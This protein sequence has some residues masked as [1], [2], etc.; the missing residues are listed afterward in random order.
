MNRRHRCVKISSS[1]SLTWWTGPPLDLLAPLHAVSDEVTVQHSH[2]H[3]DTQRATLGHSPLLP[4]G[5]FFMPP[6]PESITRLPLSASWGGRIDSDKQ[7]KQWQQGTVGCTGDTDRVWEKDKQRN[8]PAGKVASTVWLT[9]KESARFMLNSLDSQSDGAAYTSV[10]FI[11]SGNVFYLVFFFLSVALVEELLKTPVVRVAGA[12]WSS[13]ETWSS[14]SQSCAK[15]YRTRRRTCAGPEGKSAPVACR[16]SPVEYQDCNVQSCPGEWRHGQ[17]V[18][19]NG[20]LWSDWIVMVY[21]RCSGVTFAIP[22]FYPVFTGQRCFSLL[23]NIVEKSK[24][25]TWFLPL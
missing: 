6:S 24:D 20:C 13:W 25:F 1:K 14:C 3:T 19:R 9:L 4:T 10:T 15:G 16:G 17:F 2:I 11:S 23:A 8:M 7:M 21:S 22:F 12:G 18:F 5:G